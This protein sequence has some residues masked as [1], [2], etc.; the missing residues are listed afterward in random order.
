VQ[1]L[2]TACV[3]FLHK[4]GGGIGADFRCAAR[5]FR[6]LS[7]TPTHSVK[8]LAA[9][10]NPSRIEGTFDGAVHLQY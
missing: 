7:V 9:V 3:R 5:I 1:L 6:M 10:E 8:D 4:S 2:N